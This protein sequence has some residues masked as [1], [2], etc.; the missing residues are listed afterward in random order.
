MG[1]TLNKLLRECAELTV[2]RLGT[3]SQ[4]PVEIREEVI[5]ALSNEWREKIKAEVIDEMTE[6]EKSKIEKDI[7]EHKTK[8]DFENLLILVCEGVFFAIIVGILVNQITD[9]IT[10]Y[11]AEQYK[12]LITWGIVL[13]LGLAVCLY[14]LFRLVNIISKLLRS[15]ENDDEN[16]S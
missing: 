15:K 8:K 6:A 7:E 5:N 3:S 2:E 12:V 9:L 4:Y 10:Y 16:N 1:A 11:K 13:G 14:V